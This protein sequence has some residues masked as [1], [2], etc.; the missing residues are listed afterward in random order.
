MS[1]LQSTSMKDFPSLLLIVPC[2]KHCD[3]Y[4]NEENDDVNLITLEHNLACYNHQGYWKEDDQIDMG[5][6]IWTFFYF[7]SRGRLQRHTRPARGP[8]VNASLRIFAGKLK[9]RVKANVY[10]KYLGGLII[11]ATNIRTIMNKRPNKI[12]AIWNLILKNTRITG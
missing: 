10:R 2:S 5:I 1:V 9:Q 12:S 11:N 8:A 3:G 6:V 7:L 4:I